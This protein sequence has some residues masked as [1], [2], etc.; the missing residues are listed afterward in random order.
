MRRLMHWQ[1]NPVMNS[2]RYIVD[3]HRRFRKAIA[4]R[5]AMKSDPIGG[6]PDMADPLADPAPLTQRSHR[7]RAFVKRNARYRPGQ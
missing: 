5:L 2:R 1:G 3:L 4:N 6:H 7:P